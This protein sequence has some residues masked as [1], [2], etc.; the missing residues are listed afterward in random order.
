MRQSPP[1]FSMQR[2]V[3]LSLPGLTP[4]TYLRVS[5][6]ANPP[7]ST[8]TN[9]WQLASCSDAA[10]TAEL[11]ANWYN[12]AGVTN[13]LSFFVAPDPYDNVGLLLPCCL[14]VLIDYP[15]RSG[16]TPRPTLL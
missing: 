15:S 9:F 14:H 10:P 4:V 3:S 1:H 13:R 12:D 11:T 5:F 16:P 7:A 8:A 2:P 6:I